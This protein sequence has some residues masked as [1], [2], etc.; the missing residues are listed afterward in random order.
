MATIEVRVVIVQQF[1]GYTNLLDA[2]SD[3]LTKARELDE[4]AEITARYRDDGDA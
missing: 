2:V 4:P 3:V 1:T